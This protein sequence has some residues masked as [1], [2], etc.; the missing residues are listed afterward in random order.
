MSSLLP[1]FHAC[2]AVCGL[3][4]HGAEREARPYCRTERLNTRID[5]AVVA[6]ANRATTPRLSAAISLVF[7]IPQMSCS[8]MLRRSRKPYRIKAS[9][10]AKP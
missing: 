9:G 8:P 10:P 3:D 6:A 2:Y 1:C 5:S 4:S 7:D